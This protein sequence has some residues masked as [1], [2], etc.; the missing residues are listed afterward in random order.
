MVRSLPGKA[1]QF[2]GLLPTG[3]KKVK[4]LLPIP[5]SEYSALNPGHN[6]ARCAIPCPKSQAFHSQLGKVCLESRAQY[7]QV[8]KV[9]PKSGTYHCQV[10]IS[11]PESR[12]HHC[13]VCNGFS[14]ISGTLLHG[15][16]WFPPNLRYNIAGLKCFVLN[17][18]QHRS[19]LVYTRQVTKNTPKMVAFKP[20]HQI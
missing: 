2:A 12:A 10:R 11:S 6:N 16:Q 1:L 9:C 20:E 8:G 17:P 4:T 14:Q 15:V 5:R 3:R 18:K 7:S 19:L 13:M